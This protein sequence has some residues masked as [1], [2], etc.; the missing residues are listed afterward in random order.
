ME[1]FNKTQC[2]LRF[3][4]Q[5]TACSESLNADYQSTVVRTSLR[6][7]HVPQRMR[8][9]IQRRTVSQT[10]ADSRVNRVLAATI[11]AT[12]LFETAA[13]ATAFWTLFTTYTVKTFHQAF[14]E[15]TRRWFVRGNVD[16][17]LV[18]RDGDYRLLPMTSI[19]EKMSSDLAPLHARSS[20]RQ[21]MFAR[22]PFLAPLPAVPRINA[23]SSAAH[24]NLQTSVQSSP[25]YSTIARSPASPFITDSFYYACGCTVAATSGVP[26]VH[27]TAVLL[28]MT[29][30]SAT[31]ATVREWRQQ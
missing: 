18:F 9:V 21:V 16:G 17:C 27:A 11:V 1:C 22:E 25:P 15:P 23:G 6:S 30:Y 24:A 29:S 26:C 3:F 8:D 19:V 4:F 13:S 2:G 20:K 10:A 31:H 14:L 28:Q 12:G 5:G 7:K